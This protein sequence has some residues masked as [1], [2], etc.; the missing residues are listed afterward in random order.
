PM[1]TP[2]TT[3]ILDSSAIL[4]G[5]QL[6]TLLRSGEGEGSEG[7]AE[8]LIPDSVGGEMSTPQARRLF[9]ALVASGARVLTPS[10]ETREEA[11]R[12]A[13]ETGDIE[14]LSPAD[15]DVVALAL[16]TG[17]TV[18]TDD[19]S[20]QNL[21]AHMDIPW[22]PV[23]ERGIKAEWKWTYRCTGCGRDHPPGTK[24]CPVCGSPVTA[25]RA[26]P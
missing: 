3:Y 13:R 14:R 26:G 16:E 6:H 5:K 24:V 4:S 19:Y 9:E 20:I 7:G 1:K 2:K 18:V 17:G 25:R 23:S 21:C 11:E 15:M 8:A 10:G 12:A 22:R